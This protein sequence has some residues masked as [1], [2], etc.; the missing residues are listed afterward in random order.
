MRTGRTVTVLAVLALVAV[1]GWHAVRQWERLPLPTSDRVCTVEADGSV[2]LDVEQMANAATIA[3]VGVRLDMPDRAVVVALATA[4]QESKLQNLPYGDRDSVGLFQQ[5]PSQG[6]GSVKEISDPGYA[7]QRFYQ[8]LR[9]VNGWQD[10]R[11]TDAAQV[12][13][14]SAFP[15]AYEK[16]ADDATVLATALLGHVGG[17]V[18]CTVPGTPSLYGE[19]ATTELGARLVEDWGEPAAVVPDESGLAI[20]AGD[21]TTGWRYAHWLVSHAAA[22]GVQWVH[23]DQLEWTADRGTWNPVEAASDHVLAQVFDDA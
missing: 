16:W 15:E 11:I 19:V 9:R 23:F 4:F 13:Q 8:A 18:A 12:V 14:R 21:A 10:M 1:L 20:I 5:R 22:L 7:A 17:A 3:A 2:T 6:W